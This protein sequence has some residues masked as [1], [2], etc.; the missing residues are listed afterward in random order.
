MQSSELPSLM[1]VRAFVRVADYGSVSKASEAL[2]R[3]QSVVTRSISEL[4]ARLGVLLFERHANGMRLTDYGTR[5]LPRARRVLAELDSVPQLLDGA[6]KART[7]PLY[8]FQAR[9]LQVFVKLCETHH[10]QTVASLLGLSQPAISSTLKVL[11]SGCGQT[12]FERTP[13]GLLPT[14][15][16]L[17]ILFP[18]RRAL[19]ELRH[20]DTDISALQGTLQGVVQVG[21]LPLGRTRILPEA[22][23][24]L[25][26]EHPGIQVITNES[27]FD[28]LA[29]E[30]RAGDVDFIFGALRSTA[31]A[32]DLSGE[33]LLTEEMVVLARRGHPL[34]SKSTVQAEL[35]D[36]QWVLPRA[37][38][39]AR[40]MLDDC[41]T[42]FGI[43]PPRP[44]VE[45]GDMAIIRGLLLRSDMLAAVSAHQLE[46]EIAS[47]ELCI[48]PLELRHTSRAI[49]LTSRTAS[50]HS[51]V[52]KALMDV[53]RQVIQ[54]Q[55][56]EP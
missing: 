2:F 41:F 19:N 46:A 47:G 50:L 20:I 5:L 54:E 43:A 30:L 52:A 33:A 11:E 9:R 25:M 35:A 37:G 10:M 29:T 38:S 1:H 31:Y 40:H 4:E 12:L 56:P 15:A 23:V 7:E 49:G 26:R 3:A 34:Y 53:I 6:D 28:L 27:P 16:S 32:S 39:P 51:P 48:L 22:I 24:R 44:M 18:V 17:D 14:R 8:L 36:A 13:R 21:A 45:S 42:A 55:P